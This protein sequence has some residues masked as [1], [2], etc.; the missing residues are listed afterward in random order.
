MLTRS[1]SKSGEELELADSSTFHEVDTIRPWTQSKCAAAPVWQE[2]QSDGETAEASA[3]DCEASLEIQDQP[4]TWGLPQPAPR[5]CTGGAYL[6]YCGFCLFLTSVLLI[7]SVWE[8][9]MLNHTE[10]RLWERKLR[11]WEECC[12]AFVGAALCT[13]TFI[14]LQNGGLRYFVRDC[15]RML[16]AAVAALTLLCGI[17]FTLR[18]VAA[19]ADD[20]LE[21]IDVPILALRFAL[22]PVRMCSTASMVVRSIRRRHA[23]RHN[24]QALERMDDPRQDVVACN[25]TS[26]LPTAAALQI[27]EQLPAH[28]RF[29]DWQLVYSPNVHG[30]SLRTFYRAQSG[31][32]IIV[33][34][35]TGGAVFGGF[36]MES[37]RQQDCAY[38]SAE[39][40]VF[41]V[42]RFRAPADGADVLPSAEATPGSE[43][44]EAADVEAQMPPEEL[45]VDFHRAVTTRGRIVQWSDEKQLGLGHAIVVQDDFLRGSSCSCDSFGSPPMAATGSDFVVRDFECWAI[46]R[47][48]E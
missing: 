34:R 35:D 9:M 7:T 22:Q 16:D 44:P 10:A 18:R 42:R 12:E 23:Q 47:R 19:R 28:L 14:L 31:P 21:D 20:V 37:W 15:W 3:T 46:S 8:G 2:L 11:P 6:L 30:T 41:A 39:S 1:G 43:F 13:E 40:F 32:N 36:A 45:S 17:F 5:V 33:V 48:G 29:L 25:F 38:G 24:R 27:R 4:L 26:A